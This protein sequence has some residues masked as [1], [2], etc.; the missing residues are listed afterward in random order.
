MPVPGRRVVVKVKVLGNN[1][2]P[3]SSSG[4][5]AH[6]L[7][8]EQRRSTPGGV[9]SLDKCSS[10]QKATKRLVSKRLADGGRSKS[11]QGQ[12]QA[13]A[14]AVQFCVCVRCCVDLIWLVHYHTFP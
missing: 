9:S 12:A 7:T 10:V 1:A 2:I 11:R 3:R 8:G 14:L 5:W 4:G 6:S 13:D